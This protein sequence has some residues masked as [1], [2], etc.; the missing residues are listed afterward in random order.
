MFG[1]V[2]VGVGLLGI[3]ETEREACVDA[4][5]E[6]KKCSASL[7]NAHFG[8]LVIVQLSAGFFKDVEKVNG[9][10]QLTDREA[11]RRFNGRQRYAEEKIKQERK[12]ARE[13]AEGGV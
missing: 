9:Y 7:K 6:D 4:E 13:R 2:K 3:G 10:Y 1:V 5:M 8:N 12:K 11:L